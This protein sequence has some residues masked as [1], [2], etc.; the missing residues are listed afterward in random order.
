M[1]TCSADFVLRFRSLVLAPVF[2][3]MRGAIQRDL[4]QLKT[5]LEAG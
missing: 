2:Y 1:P 5:V 4:R 3:A